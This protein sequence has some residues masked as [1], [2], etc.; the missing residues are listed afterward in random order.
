MAMPRPA[1]LFLPGLLCDAAVWAKQVEGLRGLAETSVADLTQDDSIVA[2]ARRA[3]EMAGDRRLVV[4]ALSMGGYVAFELLRTIPERIAGVALFDTAASPDAPE[5][6]AERKAGIASLA[7]GRFVGVTSR[8]ASRL[9]HPDRIGGPLGDEVRAM[10]QRV[11]SQAYLRQQQAILG[12]QDYRPVLAGIRASTL[13][14]VGAQDMLTPLDEA[15]L[16]HESVPGSR[17]HVFDHCG[18]LPPLEVPEEANALLREW[19]QNEVF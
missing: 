15:R 3:S 2:M 10:A 17:F 9:I 14:A 1:V 16:I 8:M 18:H 7:A 12:R 6:V 4:V 13:V 5:R 19:L 11:G